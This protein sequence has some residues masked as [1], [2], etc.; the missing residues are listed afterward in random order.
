MK[1]TLNRIKCKILQLSILAGALFFYNLSVN[2]E[3]RI[4]SS[5]SLIIP[6]QDPIVSHEEKKL[7]NIQD[8]LQ[9]DNY[10]E[11]SAPSDDS[12]F[13]PSVDAV[14]RPINQKWMP[15]PQRA[16]ILSAVIPGLGQAYNH[17]YWKIPIIYTVGAGLYYLYDFQNELFIKYRRRYQEDQING[18]P[19]NVIEYS[20][21]YMDLAE[22]RRDYAVIYAGILYIANIVDAMADAYFLQ[23]DISD[24][25]SVQLKPVLMP[26]YLSQN[27]YSC[28]VRL[29]IQF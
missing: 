20:K 15:S 25:L 10:S 21:A 27:S 7:K 3:N 6:D 19:S 9:S 23:Y 12:L 29:C 13:V 2:S 4:P 14:T 1:I 22:K 28:G 5:D 16:T 18:A 24:D 17:K 11:Y 8:S 26:S